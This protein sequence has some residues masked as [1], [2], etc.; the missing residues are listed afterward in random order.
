L[1]E[2]CLCENTVN[3][4]LYYAKFFHDETVDGIKNVVDIMS[5][6]YGVA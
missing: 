4:V 3:G 1:K 2:K 6:L 5:L